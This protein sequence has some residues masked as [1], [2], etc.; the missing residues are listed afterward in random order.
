MAREYAHATGTVVHRSGVEGAGSRSALAGGYRV[1]LNDDAPIYGKPG[2]DRFVARTVR[3]VDAT[4]PTPPWMSSRLRLAGIR[5][6]SLPVDISNYVMLELGQ[7]L[8]FYDLDKLSGGHRGPPRRR[9]G[10][11][12]GPWTARNARSTPRTC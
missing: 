4:R 11:S 6:I 2:C 5:S 8:H 3:G 7:P 12:S 10:R 1:K 9:R